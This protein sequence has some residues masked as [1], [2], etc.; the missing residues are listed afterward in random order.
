MKTPEEIDALT[1]EANSILNCYDR[2]FPKTILMGVRDRS[3]ES[4]VDY[5]NDECRR[6]LVSFMS[7]CREQREEI[8]RLNGKTNFCA[9]C[10]TLARQF[11]EKRA[12]WEEL[13]KFVVEE[14]V[15]CH[16]SDTQY[17]T[18][19]DHGA[20]YRGSRIMCKIEEL[21]AKKGE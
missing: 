1:K 13:R 12:R 14:F 10:E 21:E 9:G 5:C 17:D 15:N 20:L 4:S 11:A 6:L 2:V 19:F 3:A 8:A 7:L 16:P 18:P